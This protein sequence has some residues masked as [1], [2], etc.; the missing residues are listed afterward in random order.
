MSSGAKSI[1]SGPRPLAMTT[2]T[3]P[4]HVEHRWED[5]LGHAPDQPDSQAIPRTTD[6]GVGAPGFRRPVDPGGEEFLQRQPPGAGHLAIG[7]RRHLRGKGEAEGADK[8]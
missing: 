7:N 2:G 4:H 6:D 1:A 3:L 5:P 8:K